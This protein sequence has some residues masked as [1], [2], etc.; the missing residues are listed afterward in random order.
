MRKDF[1]TWSLYLN[2]HSL[3]NWSIGIDYYHEKYFTPQEFIAMV[4]QVNFLFF[5][6]TVTK[7][8]K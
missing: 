1:K 4:F 6:I 8:G 2:S 3:T 5:N 7:W